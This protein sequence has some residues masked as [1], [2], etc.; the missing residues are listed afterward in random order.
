MF[1]VIRIHKEAE[2]IKDWYESAFLLKEIKMSHGSVK[3][4]D[5]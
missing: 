4:F 3:C 5:I 1:V 2:V